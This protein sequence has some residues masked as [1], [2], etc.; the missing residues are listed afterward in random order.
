LVEIDIKNSQP[1]FIGLVAKAAGVDCDEYLRLCEADLYRH[2]ADASGF[3]RQQVKEQLMKRALF[4][5][6]HAPA[7]K[8]PVKRLFDKLFPE[9]AEFI[10]QQK[11]GQRTEGDDTPHGKLAIKAQYQESKFV[12]YTVCER[13]R[14]ERPGCWIATIHDSI[15]SL[16]DNVEYV[17][18]V[19]RDEFR[20]LGVSPR[21]EPRQPGA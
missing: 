13:I 4:S 10:R 18:A 2:L 3:T 11:K 9:M 12:I 8:L 15:L 21:L 17:L 19:M 6:N 20:K 1:L 16:P 7:Q 14:K 5:T